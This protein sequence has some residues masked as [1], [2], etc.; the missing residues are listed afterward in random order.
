LNTGLPSKDGLK[1]DNK[2]DSADVAARRRFE[3]EAEKAKKRLANEEVEVQA[4][5]LQDA[6]NA[7]KAVRMSMKGE[8]Q[9][10][11]ILRR[12]SMTERKLTT[13]SATPSI[14]DLSSLAKEKK[15]LESMLLDAQNDLQELLAEKQETIHFVMLEDWRYSVDDLG[16]EVDILKKELAAIQALIDIDE[17]ELYD[18]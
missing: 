3:K 14:S 10:D 9:Q 5:A 12:R 2:G 6:R 1:S 7:I 11:K 16:T 13:Q 15:I 4:K 17:D 8:S 18:V